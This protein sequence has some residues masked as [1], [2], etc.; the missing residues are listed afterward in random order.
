[1]V[2]LWLEKA[3]MRPIYRMIK[4][5]GNVLDIQ[6]KG[7]LAIADLFRYV[8]LMIAACAIFFPAGNADTI[9]AARRRD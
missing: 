8:E 4:N 1:M 7:L 2:L 6:F 3:P 5:I 9:S